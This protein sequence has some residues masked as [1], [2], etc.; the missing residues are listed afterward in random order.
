[1]HACI[2]TYIH[3][4][5]SKQSS[6]TA[7][8]TYPSPSQII[9]LTQCHVIIA[10]LNTNYILFYFAV[11]GDETNR[12]VDELESAMSER[13]FADSGGTLSSARMTEVLIH[14][15]LLS[16]EYQSTVRR[17]LGV[18]ATE[19]PFQ[20]HLPTAMADDNV[21]APVHLVML[22][23]DFEIQV[24]DDGDG[25]VIAEGM[26]VCMYACLYVCM[27]VRMYVCVFVCMYVCRYVCMYV[28]MYA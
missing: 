27:Y 19:V 1:M 5:Q 21:G 18:D 25:D 13:Q 7:S 16:P 2:Y 6:A 12:L 23:H 22:D 10:R 28:G 4:K 8:A 14:P 9:R 26:Y 11:Q 15:F 3:A 20:V 24:T 17:N